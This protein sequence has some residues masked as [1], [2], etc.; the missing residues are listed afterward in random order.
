MATWPAIRPG[1]ST[2]AHK[3]VACEHATPLLLSALAEHGPGL[4]EALV[5]AASV[6][7]RAGRSDASGR[8]GRAGP[9]RRPLS[10]GALSQGAL[11]DQLVRTLAAISREQPLLLLFDD[12]HWVDEA[13]AAFLLHLGRELS[14]RRLLVLGAYRSATV[15]LGR[16]DLRSGETFRHPLA[17]VVNELRLQK[18]EVLIELDRA[19]GRAFV[20]A[21]V[22][23]EP[24]RL[25][26]GFRDALY[27]Q[28]GGHALF[29]VESLRNLQARGELVKDEAGR[30]VAR[31]SLDWGALPAR[32][33]A[34]IAERIERLPEVERR[35]LSVASV[36][37]DDFTAEVVAELTGAPAA[38]VLFHLSG[39]LARQ[40]S[41]VRAEGVVR[42]EGPIR[43]EEPERLGSGQRSIY[44][45]THHLFQKYL[46]D[47][48]DP[49]ERAR[50]ARRPWRPS[51][52]RQAAGDPVERERLGGPAGLALRVRQ[53]CRCRPPARC[54]TPDTRRCGCR[55]FA[56]PS[57]GSTT[58]WRCW[59]SPASRRRR[60]ARRGPAGCWRSPGWVHSA[61]WKDW[62][63]PSCRAPW[64]GPRQRGRG[65]RRTG[66][67]QVDDALGAGG[68]PVWRRAGSRRRSLVAERMRDLGDAMR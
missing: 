9:H 11:F 7:R 36:Q 8:A 16:R 64:R 40:H 68:T 57:T 27:A 38:E 17:A 67:A 29:T 32:V 47:Q 66:A 5:P 44:R 34:V 30:W 41:L 28:T 2:A 3:P 1:G 56:R 14:E 58:D 18:G 65:G 42:A 53:G 50:L 26:A 21:Y 10:Q 20:E 6:A 31:E 63:A 24:N 13:S 22:D 12:L 39:S 15:A 60:S 35:I 52:D 23:S 49:V 48:L 55:P 51:L 45:F 62:A 59:P 43:L 37:G 4:V 54:T 25:G 33:E 61:T 46:Y 19:D